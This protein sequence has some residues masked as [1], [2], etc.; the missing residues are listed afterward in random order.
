MVVAVEGNDFVHDDE[1]ETAPSAPSFGAQA[2]RAPQPRL[3]RRPLL[4]QEEDFEADFEE[5]EVKA[6][7]SELDSTDE[8]MTFAAP[9][10]H[11][12]E[13]TTGS[14]QSLAVALDPELS[15]YVTPFLVAIAVPLEEKTSTVDFVW[16]IPLSLLFSC[17]QLA[18]LYFYSSF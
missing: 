12:P 1:A 3:P 8:A 11:S 4:H 18:M 16:A 14:S 7:D 10:A 13:D 17:K 2:R 9:G 15:L 6:G 5:F